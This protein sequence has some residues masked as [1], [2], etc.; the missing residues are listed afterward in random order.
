MVVPGLSAYIL[1]LSSCIK[2]LHFTNCHKIQEPCKNV[3]P[4]ICRLFFYC[5]VK[6]TC[7]HYTPGTFLALN[8]HY[9]KEIKKIISSIL[10]LLFLMFFISY[11]PHALSSTISLPSEEL[12]RMSY[13]ADLGIIS[14]IYLF[15]MIYFTITF[16]WYFLWI[17]DSKL[18]YCSFFSL[19]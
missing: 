4:F 7:I 3:A 11:G 8:N 6:C 9:F 15:G 14:R 5:H 18:M 16:Q 2:S 19:L 12:N 10:Y 13:N 1:K 17:V